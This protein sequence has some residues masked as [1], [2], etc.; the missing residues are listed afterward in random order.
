[1]TALDLPRANW[2]VN[3]EA[4]ECQA[5]VSQSLGEAGG[6]LR[7]HSEIHSLDSKRLPLLCSHSYRADLGTVHATNIRMRGSQQC[8]HSTSLGSKLRTNHVANYSIA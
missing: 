4:P 3:R 8:A 6:L 5:L 2:E 1:M 7:P